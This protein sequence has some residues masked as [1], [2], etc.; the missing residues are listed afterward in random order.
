MLNLVIFAES[1]W[2]YT[3]HERLQ[4]KVLDIKMWISRRTSF[5][6]KQ[7]KKFFFLNI[8]GLKILP[9][10]KKGVCVWVQ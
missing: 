9:L 1:L 3:E 6:V 5:L 2:P 10:K 8:F 4:S 7:S